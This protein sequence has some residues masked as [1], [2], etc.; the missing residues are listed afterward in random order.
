LTGTTYDG[1]QLVM[2][3]IR[4]ELPPA[5]IVTLTPEG[6]AVRPAVKVF[7]GFIEGALRRSYIGGEKPA[8]TSSAA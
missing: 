4:E 8:L 1:G 2:Q 6:H 3:P 5:R 7:A